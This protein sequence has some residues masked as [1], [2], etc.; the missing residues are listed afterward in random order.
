MF[1]KYSEDLYEA[2]TCLNPIQANA[3][4]KS[5]QHLTQE[6]KSRLEHYLEFSCQAGYSIKELASSYDLIVKDTFKEQMYFRRHGHY[7]HSS[8]Q[9]VENA[10]Y[11][12]P[13]YM[14]SYMLGLAITGFLWRNHLELLRYYDQW[15]ETNV[16]GNYLEVGP[17]H[18]MYFLQ[19]IKSKKFDSCLGVDISPSSIC[20]TK[21]LLSY[22]LT[23]GEY[24][25][26][27]VLADFLNWEPQKK[28]DVVVMA[29]VLEHVEIPENFLRKIHQI[30]NPGGMIYITTCINAPAIDHIYL[31]RDVDEVSK[32]VLASGF[33][34]VDELVVPYEGTSMSQSINEK[35]PINIAQILMR[36]E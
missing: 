36:N 26:E 18:G 30:T 19:S 11:Q 3:I 14:T 12:N 9:D 4:E 15:L 27:L 32:Q 29:E 20:L 33:S 1:L 6:E 7:R 23:E 10:V 21:E 25:Y 17:G 16:H 13:K 5:Y 2:I 8:Y 31:Y 28:F 22:V 35:L 24:N 34:I